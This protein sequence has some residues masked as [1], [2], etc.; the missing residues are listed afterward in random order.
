METTISN[1]EETNTKD[2]RLESYL[3]A[4]M[5]TVMPELWH[6]SSTSK[7]SSSAGECL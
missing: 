4:K 6:S 5:M 2:N 1:V 3:A 7:I